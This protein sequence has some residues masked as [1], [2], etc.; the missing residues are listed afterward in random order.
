M[1]PNYNDFG[2]KTITLTVEGLPNC[3]DTQ[4]VEVFY[5]GTATNH[6]GG[7][8]T[9]PNWFHYYQQNEGGTDYTYGCPNGRSGSLS[10][11][12]GSVEICDEAYQGDEYITTNVAAGQLITTGVSGT[13]RY[14]GNF[15]GVLAHERQHANNQINTGPPADRDSDRL[16]NAFETSTSQ[17][18]PDDDCS[19]ARPPFSCPPFFDRE[20]YA[21]GPVEEAG[22]AGANVSQDWADP[23]SN[24]R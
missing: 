4:L 15:L 12:P 21:G 22:I 8:P 24:H 3:Q 13:N 20:V 14:Y 6:P 2:P 11:I 5:P 1:P 7:N 10:G 23:G 17:T 18:N 9:F 19:A 16:A